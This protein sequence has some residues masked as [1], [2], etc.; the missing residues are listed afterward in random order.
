MEALK[1]KF[2]LD[3]TIREHN[4]NQYR[5]YIRVK[6]MDKFCSLVRPYFHTSMMYKLEKGESS[7]GQSEGKSEN[8]NYSPIIQLS[9]RGSNKF[10]STL[11]VPG[12]SL[13][14]PKQYNFSPQWLTGFIQSSGCFTIAFKKYKSGLKIRPRPIFSLAQDFSEKEL[15]IG[16]LKYL[17]VGYIRKNKNNVILEIKSLEHLKDVL[18]PIL[19]KHPLKYGKFKAYLTFKSIVEEMLNKTHL[20]LDGL[21]RIIYASFQLNVATTRRTE[22]SKNNLLKYLESQHGKLPALEELDISSLIPSISGPQKS[23]LSL[24][25]IAGLIDGD[26]S[27][28][29]AFQLKPYRRVRVNF[30][31]VQESSCKELLNELETYFSCGSVYDLPSHASRKGGCIYKLDDVNLFL[32]NLVPLLNKV[33]FNLK[34]Q[35]YKTMIKVCEILKDKKSLTN[36][37]FLNTVELAYNSKKLGKKRTISKEELISKV[38]QGNTKGA[39]KCFTPEYKNLFGYPGLSVNPSVTQKRGLRSF[40]LH[41]TQLNP[42]FVSGFLDGGGSFYIGMS[43]DE[44]RT[45]G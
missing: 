33:N 8:N 43:I 28:N 32:N 39:S 15:F 40:S 45:S 20:S 29:V 42:H 7:S 37:T 24:G 21:L 16:L 27:F 35:Y 30:T 31:V 13:S 11:S 44:K 6:S 1:D 5:I 3:C 14:L 26:G 18:F 25:F 9:R 10:F 19:D 41:N 2:S 22:E 34:D 38:L 12:P 36:D 4:P 23:P 17:G